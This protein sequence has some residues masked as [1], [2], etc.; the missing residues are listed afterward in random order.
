MLALL[1]VLAIVWLVDPNS[2]KPRIEKAVKE[3]S[4]R[5]FTLAGDIDLDFLPWLSLHTGEGRFGNAPGFG[6]D[7][8][9]SWHS[10]QLGAKLLPLLRGEL[11]VDRVKL[12]G[13]DLRLVRHADGT[14]NCRSTSRSFSSHFLASLSSPIWSTSL[15]ATACRPE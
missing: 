13:A 8:L 5:D 3:A 10:A 14:A 2:F 4:G 15:S 1:G 7:P 11:V 12:E 6:P 9:V